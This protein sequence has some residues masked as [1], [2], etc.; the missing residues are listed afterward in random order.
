MFLCN[1]D[2]TF[3]YR[4]NDRIDGYSGKD[5]NAKSDD[6]FQSSKDANDT[7]DKR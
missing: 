1:V 6:L 7:Y 2:T 4:K 3:L 5:K